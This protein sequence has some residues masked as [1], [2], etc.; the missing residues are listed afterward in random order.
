MNLQASH[1]GCWYGFHLCEFQFEGYDAII[2]FPKVPTLKRNFAIKTEY[3]NAFPEAIEIP[4]LENGFHIC[5]IKNK[6]RWGTDD[7]LDRKARFI[8][9]L[10]NTYNLHSQCTA[11]GMSCGGLIAIK[12]AAKYPSLF[13][14]LYLDAPVVNYMSCPCGFGVGKPLSADNSEI[15][16]ALGLDSISQLLSYRDM[17]L[18]KISALIDAKI[19][20]FLSAGDSDVIVPYCENGILLEDAYK[21]ADID[22]E[23]HICAGRAHHPHG[24]D[25]PS[26]I[27]NFIV[28][29]SG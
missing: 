3:W 16:N 8:C 13:S 25:N 4:L 15:L 9:Y 6:N 19:P 26:T 14:C 21:T 18:D 20:M 11:V 17:P 28:D 5:Y 7:D 12:L 1:T 2:V 29:H 24:I 23:V 22:F 27:L 10:Q